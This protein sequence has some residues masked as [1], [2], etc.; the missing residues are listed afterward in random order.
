MKMPNIVDVI[1]E[2]QNRRA[3]GGALGQF[4]LLGEGDEAMIRFMDELQGDKNVFRAVEVLEIGRGDDFQMRIMEPGEE[5]PPNARRVRRI[6]GRAFVYW[7]KNG[8]EK[9]VVKKVMI[10]DVKASSGAAAD[11][12]K[13]FTTRGTIRDSDY[14][15]SRTGSGFDTKYSLRRQDSA[16]FRYA[17]KAK[18]TWISDKQLE[19]LILKR[20]KRDKE[21]EEEESEE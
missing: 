7:I 18:E 14:L 20:Y 19:E 13:D 16:P 8:G 15:F 9:R 1:R 5:V 6:I 10:F 11:L 12:V 2:E 17:A 4:I 21:E 3:A